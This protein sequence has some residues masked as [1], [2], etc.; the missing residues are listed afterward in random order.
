[1]KVLH[2]LPGSSPAFGGPSVALPGLAQ[3]L[4]RRGVEA[5]LFTTNADPGGRLDVPLGRPID[6]AGA[7]VVYFNVWPPGRYLVSIP[8]ARALHRSL[9]Q[10]D[11]AHIH[12]LYPFSSLA[13]AVL[14]RRMRVPYVLQFNGSLDPHLMKKN[15]AVKKAYMALAGRYIVDHASA[16]IF[17]SEAERRHAVLGGVTVPSFVVPIGLHWADYATLPARGRFRKTF[18]EIKDRRIILFLG[19]ISR[20]K[21]LDLL[22]A[23]FGTILAK[24]AD[25]HLVIAGPDGEGYGRQVRQWVVDAGLE[26]RVTF[27]GRVPNELKRAAYVDSD[28]FVLP[29]YAENF[30]ATVTEAL[31]CRRPVVISDRVNICDEIARAEAGLVV[32]CSPDAVADGVGRVLDDP[33]LAER[34]SGNGYDLVQQMFTWDAALEVLLPIYETVAGWPTDRRNGGRPS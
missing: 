3:A 34:L 21:G 16:L 30:G 10:Y 29:S 6:Q 33:A 20:Q 32:A 27:A 15:A 31:A 22:V 28:V 2:V 19:R 9:R 26:R 25:A 5:C 1:M 23:A 18:P 17:T 4:T 8:L 11:V 13:T 14:A 12:W 24:H 7:T